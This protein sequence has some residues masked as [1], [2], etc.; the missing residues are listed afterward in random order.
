MSWPAIRAIRRNY[1]EAEIHVLTRPKFSEA[2]TGLTAIHKIIKMPT[3]EILSPLVKLNMEVQESFDCLS[4]FVDSLY[5]ENYDWILNLS[6]SPFS[7][8]LTHYLTQ[9]HTRVTGYSRFHDGYFSIPD[10]MS[11]YFYAQVGPGRPNRFHLI[12][13]F[14]SMAGLDL[15]PEDWRAPHPF[16]ITSAVLP[17]EYVVIHVGASES[18]KSLS[19]TKWTNII[20]QIY[21]IQ[22]MK[23]VLIGSESE[24]I[25]STTICSGV[26]EGS[27]LDLVGKTSIQELFPIIKKSRLLVGCD[28]APMHM[29]TLVNTPCVNISLSTV[30]FWETGPRTLDS[31]IIKEKNEQ[32]LSSEKVAQI[33][34]R[35]FNGEKQDVGVIH[36]TAG[37]PSYWALMPKSQD[38]DWLLIR[39][40]YIGED[41]PSNESKDFKEAI[42]QLS[43]V[44]QLMIHQMENVEKTGLIAN[45]SP[46]IERGE[47]IIE[48]I[49]KL[50]P[51]AQALIRWYQTEKIRI[52]PGEM[53]VVL[54]R[55]L[56]IHR[57]FQKILDLY[58]QF[59]KIPEKELT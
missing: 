13:I 16:P 29:A 54:N 35:Q 14:A 10:D 12:E 26:P 23:F 28:S 55:T 43:E 32:E 27:V 7:S 9:P 59:Q 5:S 53:K 56:E 8:Y 6:F 37:T 46:F 45:A 38:F 18:S 19:A 44:N 34:C 42:T 21:K 52:G 36:A 39:A 2:F 51:P 4:E 41:F 31:V 47:E 57:L 1:P 50:V 20:N 30:N 22:K 48:T 58:S 40:I 33:I 3:K 11:A 25:I 17:D 15:E 24:K 49:G